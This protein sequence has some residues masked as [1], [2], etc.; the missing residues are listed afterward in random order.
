MLVT[1]NN[2]SDLPEVKS[3]STGTYL[4]S[5]FEQDL[6]EQSDIVILEN[7]MSKLQSHENH[8]LKLTLKGNISLEARANLT[9]SLQKWEARLASLI[10]D[11]TGL[12]IRPNEKDLQIFT[13]IGFLNN[14]LKNLIN[15]RD[16]EGNEDQSYAGR[17]IQLLWQQLQSDKLEEL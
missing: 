1:L 17:A 2:K 9:S 13:S 4:W 3:L 11:D 16:D 10:I 6:Y 8:V 7:W 12:E 15:I 14:T 5:D